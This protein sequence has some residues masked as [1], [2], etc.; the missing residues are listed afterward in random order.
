MKK[1]ALTYDEMEAE[2]EEVSY[3]G[4]FSYGVDPIQRPVKIYIGFENSSQKLMKFLKFMPISF[5][6]WQYKLPSALAS[7]H[8]IIASG[9]FE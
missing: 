2:R 9:K 6:A 7:R 8:S 5:L 3:L 1:Q 4:Y